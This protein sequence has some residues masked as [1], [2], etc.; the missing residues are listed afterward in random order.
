LEY[1]GHSPSIQR[2]RPKP[3]N[4]FGRKR[5]QLTLTERF[6]GKTDVLRFRFVGMDFE[7]FNHAEFFILETN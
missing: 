4:G 7:H 2:I 5:N 6:R 1:P 3:I